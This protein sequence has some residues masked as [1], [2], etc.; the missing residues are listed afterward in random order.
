MAVAGVV[1]KAQPDPGAGASKTKK[2]GKKGRTANTGHPNESIT[3]PVH[4]G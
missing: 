1:E 3:A 4:G 2:K